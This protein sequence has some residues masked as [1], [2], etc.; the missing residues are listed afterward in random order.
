MSGNG[1]T[2]SDWIDF[3]Q[4]NKPQSNALS[5]GIFVILVSGLQVGWIF[6]SDLLNFPWAEGHST[7]QI[8]MTYASFY[9]G[10]VIGLYGAAMVVN[11]LT[12]TNIYV[13][14]TMRQKSSDM[15]QIPYRAFFSS[16]Q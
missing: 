15:S 8:I 6:S 3:N 11:R 1:G 16:R 5:G 2:M 13:S 9:I 7:V 12:K 10:G 14:C 4:K